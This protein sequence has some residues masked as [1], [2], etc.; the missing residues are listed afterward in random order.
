M[1]KVGQHVPGP[2]FR[3]RKLAQGFLAP[4]A[5]FLLAFAQQAQKIRGFTFETQERLQVANVIQVALTVFDGR[6]ERATNVKTY[7]FYVISHKWVLSV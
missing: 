1:G 7:R 3:F 6:T 2:Q 5:I 4:L